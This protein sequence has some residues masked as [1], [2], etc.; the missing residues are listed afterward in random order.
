MSV[1]ANPPPRSIFICYRR[2]DSEEVVD[3]IYESFESVFPKESLFRDIDTIPAGVDF[4]DYIQEALRNCHVVLVFIGRD[5]LSA[6]DES[7]GRRLDDANDHV[8][9]EVETA[10]HVAGLRVIP[11]LVRRA[12]MPT[13]TEL[14][15]T[16]GSLAFRNA[17]PVRTGSDYH[18]DVARL[19]GAVQ[20]ALTEWERENADRLVEARR[21]KIAQFV[22]EEPENVELPDFELPPGTIYISHAYEN[23][24]AARRIAEALEAE[25]LSVWCTH[26][27]GTPMLR[28]AQARKAVEQCALF[29]PLISQQTENHID[30]FF[31]REWKFAVSGRSPIVPT[32]VDP[33]KPRVDRDVLYLRHYD[34]HA[35]P[36]EFQNLATTSC[37]S[38]RTTAEFVSWVKQ[39][40]ASDQ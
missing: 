17:I 21:S 22:P 28:E 19:A 18:G 30:G 32:L 29:L 9:I 33:M 4:R 20:K 6:P 26:F 40:V 13:E 2:L 24:N 3:R 10:L 8:R 27:G 23:R 5:W 14:P 15:P 7:G 35:V 1:P 36:P 37:P 11:V 25:G 38:G 31:R 12:A 39:L 16:L 34:V